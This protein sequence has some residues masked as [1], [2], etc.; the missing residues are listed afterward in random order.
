MIQ[1]QTLLKVADNSGAKIVKCIKVLGGFRKKF[2][3]TG[4]VVV[5]SVLKLRNK[6]RSISKV[7]KGEI[8]KALIIRTKKELKKKSF[9]IYF[10]ENHV[11]LISLQCKPI[12]TRIFGPI[13][14][15]LKK[16]KWIKL[17]S[18]SS[19]FL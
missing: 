10:K 12:A 5:V 1:Q 13:P 8:Y 18:L 4:D 15:E 2:A 3:Y 14:K 9:N 7:K 17:N 11:C 16:N 6:S 19:G